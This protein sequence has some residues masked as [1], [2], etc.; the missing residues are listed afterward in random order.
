MRMP[1]DRGFA[2]WP[3][4]PLMPLPRVMSFRAAILSTG[5][6]HV[7]LIRRR[8]TRGN[9]LGAV[10]TISLFRSCRRTNSPQPGPITKPW[11]QA[12]KSIRPM[13]VSRPRVRRLAIL[14]AYAVPTRDVFHAG[15]PEHGLRPCRRCR[16]AALRLGV[17][18]RVGIGGRHNS[19]LCNGLDMPLSIAD[20]TQP[21]H[22]PP[23]N[24]PTSSRTRSF[25]IRVALLSQALPDH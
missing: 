3:S 1:Q 8:P 12:G 18:V 20:R 10:M 11:P 21:T 4:W 7:A 24:Y 17:G 13:I 22:N 6:S 2:E 14:T 9:L 19:I 5:V 23:A 15:C 16:A 25:T